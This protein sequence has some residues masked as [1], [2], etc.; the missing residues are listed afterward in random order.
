[1][2]TLSTLSQHEIRAYK[3]SRIILYALFTVLCFYSVERL[4]FPSQQA[5]YDFAQKKSEKS[6]Q[7]LVRKDLDIPG[8]IQDGAPLTLDTE[9]LRQYAKGTLQLTLGKENT[10]VVQLSVSVRK[11][12]KSLFFPKKMSYVEYN[13]DPEIKRIVHIG[14]RYYAVSGENLLTPFVSEQ[15]LLSRHIPIL[16]EE[17]TKDF[18]ENRTIAESPIGFRNG[19]LLASDNTVFVVEH[20]N[21]Y[22]IANVPTFESFGFHWDNIINANS[23]EIGMYKKGH[24]FTVLDSHVEGTLFSIENQLWKV[25]DHTLFPVLQKELGF[26][27]A[28]LAITAQSENFTRTVS[29]VAIGRKNIFGEQT[30]SCTVDLSPLNDLPGNEYLLEISPISTQPETQNAIHIDR[31]SITL[32]QDISWS[33]LRQALSQIKQ[34]IAERK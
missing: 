33:N 12:Y 25:V 22:P 28:S 16:V 23:E 21:I 20:E 6:P 5:L 18:L 26:D 8:I 17:E 30:A 11:G 2:S 29:C 34:M 14:E 4:L 10:E 31:A 7:G 27:A 9:T 15:A 19:S 32:F 24:Q 1:M 3:I 13:S